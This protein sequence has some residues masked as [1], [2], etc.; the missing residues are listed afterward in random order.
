LFIFAY[1]AAPGWLKEIRGE[2]VSE[3]VEY[4]ISS[5]VYRARIPFHPKRLYQLFESK[6]KDF[7]HILRGKGFIWYTLLLLFLLLFLFF[8]SLRIASRNMWIGEWEKAGA[9]YK[10]EGGAEWYCEQPEDEWLGD[11]EAIHNDF[12]EGSDRRQEMVRWREYFFLLP[13]LFT[14]FI[15]SGI[16]R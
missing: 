9:L 8:L 5:F 3:T 11:K 16:M 15:V 4:G 6:K 7:S 1:L 14:L 13:L 2:H 12:V 10:V